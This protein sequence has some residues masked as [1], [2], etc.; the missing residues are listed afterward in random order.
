MQ[1][2]TKR[3][4]ARE[5]TKLS[6]CYPMAKYSNDEIDILA[7][8]WIDDLENTDLDVFQEAIKKHRKTSEY[9]PTIKNLM[10]HCQAIHN[11]RFRNTPRLQEPEL[12]LTPEQ[13]AENIKK[14]REI[15]RKGIDARK[16]RV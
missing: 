10:D 3:E 7:G 13:V 8:I 11:E 12:D 6:L 15:I 2:I 1:K 16:N 9:F 14:V 5:I 4:V